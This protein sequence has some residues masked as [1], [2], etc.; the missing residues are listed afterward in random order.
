MTA[1]TSA[2]TLLEMGKGCCPFT[3]VNTG[4][5]KVLYP[6]LVEAD[7]MLNPKSTKA[8]LTAILTSI[9]VVTIPIQEEIKVVIEEFKDTKSFWEVLKVISHLRTAELAG[10]LLIVGIIV[11][12]LIHPLE[13]LRD[14]VRRLLEKFKSWRQGSWRTAPISIANVEVLPGQ[15]EALKAKI[16][17]G[18]RFLQEQKCPGRLEAKPAR[19]DAKNLIVMIFGGSNGAIYAEAL[20]VGL[21]SPHVKA[22]QFVT[23]S[24]N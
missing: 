7:I 6:I 23:L 8:A 19:D 13:F 22:I 12:D 2:G 21:L 11:I 16:A 10:L 15:L 4:L 9:L 14:P 18:N 1:L 3:E 24:G 5:E 17:E 20:A